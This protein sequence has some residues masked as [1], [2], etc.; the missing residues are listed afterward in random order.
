M[1]SICLEAEDLEAPSWSSRISIPVEI[2]MCSNSL[3]L[4]FANVSGMYC[5]SF[6]SSMGVPAPSTPLRTN[7]S[8]L[9]NLG[10]EGVW[11]FLLLGGGVLQMRFQ[12]KQNF[13][14]KVSISSEPGL[15]HTDLKIE[16]WLFNSFLQ[17]LNCG[18][19]EMICFSAAGC[20]CPAL[21]FS[22]LAFKETKSKEVCQTGQWNFSEKNVF[23]A[24]FEA[25]A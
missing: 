20:V 17:P 23:T 21:C 8:C 4:I 16:S 3:L 22:L 9:R 13:S 25:V 5:F 12:R 2:T 7:S 10:S 11:V 24:M 14:F 1:T 15:G 19:S 6:L 18:S